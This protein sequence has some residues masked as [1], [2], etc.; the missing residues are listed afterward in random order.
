MNWNYS[1]WTYIYL[2]DS[3]G[4]DP[5]L[6]CSSLSDLT[7]I[8]DSLPA[9]RPPFYLWLNSTL[10]LSYPDS[11]S[12]NVLLDSCNLTVLSHDCVELH[13]YIDFYLDSLPGPDLY[14]WL[15]T[16][17]ELSFTVGQY[18]EWFTM[19]DVDSPFTLPCNIFDS[20]YQVYMNSGTTI[21]MEDWMNP[22]LDLDLTYFEYV[23]LFNGCFAIPL[24]CDTILEIDSIFAALPQPKPLFY[25]YAS[26]HFDLDPLLY[27]QAYYDSLLISCGGSISDTTDCDSLQLMYND[28]LALNPSQDLTT[29]FNT[30]L[31]LGF[32]YWDYQRWFNHCD[33]N[34]A[35]PCDTLSVLV[36]YYNLYVSEL[37]V[38][39]SWLNSQLG[40]SHTYLEYLEML[41][42]CNLLPSFCDSLDQAMQA[43]LASYDST[44]TP[45]DFVNDYLDKTWT[46]GQLQSELQ[47]CHPDTAGGLML[48]DQGQFPAVSIDS[49][50]ILGCLDDFITL[51]Y[52]NAAHNFQLY[53]DSLRGEFRNN[54]MTHCLE[55]MVDS[56]YVD[57]PLSEYHYTLYYYDQA[58]N[59][60]ATIPPNG[61]HP[62]MDPDTF[63]MISD[64]RLEVPS[65]TPIY[66]TSPFATIYNYNSLNKPVAQ[67]TP[68]GGQSIYFYDNVGRVVISQNEK[69]FWLANYSY[70]LYDALGRVEEV[71]KIGNFT[72]MT[73]V[74]SRNPASFLSWI[75]S[76]TRQEVTKT[77]YDDAVYTVPGFNQENLRNR[78][79]SVIFMRDSYDTLNYFSASHYS[80]D[81]SGNVKSLI[82]E[83]VTLRDI[84]YQF[85]RIDYDYDLISGKVNYVYYQKDSVDQFTHRYEYDDDNRLTH[86]YTSRDGSTWD[87]DAHYTYYMHGP[88]ARVELGENKVQGIDYAYTLQGWMKGINASQL[89]PNRDMGVD[90]FDMTS[91]VSRDAYGFNLGYFDQ[92]YSPIGGSNFEAN[93]NPSG[94]STFGNDSYLN[95]SPMDNGLYNGNIRHSVLAMDSLNF[96]NLG[97]IYKYDQLNR[98]TAQR[99]YNGLDTSSHEWTSASALED[100]KENVVYDPNGNI[101][102]YERNATTN[103]G[104]FFKMDSLRYH[105]MAG[106]NMLDH[107][108]DTILATNYTED[109]DDQDTLN[110]QYDAIGNLIYDAAENVQYGWNN[111]GKLS[112]TFSAE[113]STY[114][115]DPMGNRIETFTEHSGLGTFD[116]LYHVRDA[117]GN[118]MATYMLTDGWEYKL[119]E[120]NI[121]G[122]SR[123][124][125][126]KADT[127][128][129]DY[130]TPTQPDFY[131]AWSGKKMYELTNHL[132]NVLSTV[133]DKKVLFDNDNNNDA[134]WSIPEIATANDYYPFGML[135][136]GRNSD[137]S[138]RFGFNGKENL[139]DV[140]GEGKLQDFGA[141]IYDGRLGRW[142]AV[143]PLHA[144]Y[145]DLS[146]YN[147]AGNSPLIF[148]DSDGK[149]FINPYT[150][151]VATAK[152]NVSNSQLVYDELKKNNP[153][154]T[155]KQLKKSLESTKLISSIKELQL[156]QAKEK[157]VETYLYTLK[158]TNKGEYD[159]FDGLTDKFNKSIDITVIL[160]EENTSGTN[161]GKVSGFATISEGA[162]GKI[163]TSD[164]FKIELY[165]SALGRTEL[166][167]TELRSPMKDYLSDGGRNYRTFSNELGDIKY[168]MQNVNDQKSLDKWS[169]T[170]SGAGYDDP[171]GAGQSSFNY[172]N[173]R[174][175][176]VKNYSPAEGERKNN[177]KNTIEK[178]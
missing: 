120:L 60:V 23:N 45:W 156:L 84:G 86:V 70:T 103:N 127:V 106:T 134:D 115:Y 174:V 54:Y 79:A 163:P 171:T 74:I 37:P 52:H 114:Y 24:P 30:E 50:D 97:Y 43:Y 110:Y 102:T 122:S 29:W 113:M 16:E 72:S 75:G 139:N 146:S 41:D 90:G 7:I 21:A 172:E 87:E 20:L 3:C 133:T 4:I 126:L 178:Q 39:N 13:T 8:F 137:S 148:Y 112:I 119:K 165:E 149:K 170:S 67:Q 94:G 101:L 46:A 167:S 169:N 105:Y 19:C 61:V 118:I 129:F 155:S 109:I 69:Q 82:Q 100:Y 10:N 78:V 42:S 35:V 164:G 14:S 145:A 34:I 57:G 107:V 104:P 6:P 83:V 131:S 142:M 177:V 136:P 111:N 141:R 95:G 80:Y 153:T 108:H 55:S 96:P 17:L 140:K 88:L 130:S 53:K 77:Y 89:D 48:C 116:Q 147:F 157:E 32:D 132:G 128:I 81:I 73:E 28:F 68:D 40:L 66:R 56:F 59:L 22:R 161:V 92:D 173:A 51:A 176:D 65:S 62:F 12:V 93:Y 64:Y 168:F 138:Y 18:W 154:F 11:N 143:D 158:V 159:Y 124:G 125:V 31:N 123:L 98:L 117:Q 36:S 151:Q 26:D 5:F 1:I 91:P 47:I 49:L 71:G 15:N 9:P 99:A 144:E 162:D 166:P 160:S 76:G 38:L 121:Y 63:Q 2:L 33:I 85:K 44:V 152:T 135:M 27:T 25:L 58:G 150:N 175:N